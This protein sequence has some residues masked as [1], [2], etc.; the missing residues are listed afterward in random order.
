MYAVIIWGYA[1][2]GLALNTARDLGGRFAAMTIFGAKANGGR[3]AAI[4]A[5]TNIFATP[6]SYVIY[7]VAFADSARG[8]C[9]LAELAIGWAT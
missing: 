2:P 6:L 3:Y 8:K 1:G 7:Q 5:L 4:A 9:S